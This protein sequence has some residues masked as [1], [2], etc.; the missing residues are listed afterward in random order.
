MK[1]KL[2]TFTSIITLGFL[3][4]TTQAKTVTCQIGASNNPT[5][6]GKCKFYRFKGGSFSLEPIGKKTFDGETT[7]ISVTVMGKDKADVRG[8]TT[9]GINARWGEMMRS[10]KQPACW[11]DES[12]KICAW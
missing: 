3:A 7:A 11:G 8:L 4:Q 12:S 6:Q 9:G 2:I 1:I 5:Y 10:K